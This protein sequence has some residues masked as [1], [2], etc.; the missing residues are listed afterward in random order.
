MRA[1]IPK[2]VN[3]GRTMLNLLKWMKML[4]EGEKRLVTMIGDSGVGKSATAIE[5]ANLLS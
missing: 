4:K 5:L 1:S 3:C 2:Y